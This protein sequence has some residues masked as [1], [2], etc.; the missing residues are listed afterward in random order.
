M[1]R[2]ATWAATIYL[3]CC[4]LG[5]LTKRKSTAWL[6]MMFLF[7]IPVTLGIAMAINTVIYAIEADPW[8]VLCSDGLFEAEVMIG[9]VASAIVGITITSEPSKRTTPRSS[10]RGRRSLVKSNGPMR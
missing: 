10:A 2:L 6:G 1:D 7:F 3:L 9:L 4:F 5:W 8:P